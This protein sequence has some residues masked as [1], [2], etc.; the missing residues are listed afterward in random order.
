MEFTRTISSIMLA[1][2]A[3]CTFALNNQ[4]IVNLL[5]KQ[6]KQYKHQYINLKQQTNALHWSSLH[7]P[8]MGSAVHIIQLQN[9]PSV[10]YLHFVNMLLV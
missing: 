10:Y 3:S 8:R 7:G 9:N 1:T 5:N 4:E 2:L 6:G